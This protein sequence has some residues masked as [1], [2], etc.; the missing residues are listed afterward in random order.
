[1]PAAGQ[2]NLRAEFPSAE[3]VGVERWKEPAEVDLAKV[4]RSIGT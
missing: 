1:L 3:A 4:D 2:S